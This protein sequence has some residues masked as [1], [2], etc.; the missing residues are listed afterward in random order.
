MMNKTK[1]DIG[2][3]RNKHPDFFG[4]DIFD[5]PCVDLTWDLE[6]FPWPINDNSFEY[7]K[8]IHVIEHINDQAGLFKEIHRITKNNGIIHIE[9]PHFSSESSWGDPTHVRHFS[10]FFTD[11]LCGNGYLADITGRYELIH[12]RVNFG[13]F[14]GSIHARFIS[15]VLGYR[16][17]ERSAFTMPARN[18]Y[19]DLKVCK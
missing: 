17:W 12:R 2:C 9:T 7:V 3:G 8:L 10:L 4:I 14:F 6:N 19:I 18:I 5:W 15:S 11:Q 13:G 1:L 16:K